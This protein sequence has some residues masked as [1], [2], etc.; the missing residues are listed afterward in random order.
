[1]KGGFYDDSTAELS[2]LLATWHH[3]LVSIFRSLEEFMI[4]V[5]VKIEFQCA[6]CK[7]AG[8]VEAETCFL[9]CSDCDAT[10]LVEKYV[11]LEEF[12]KLLDGNKD[13]LVLMP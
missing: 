10:G 11:S 3:R 8:E 5:R 1:M 2:H 13:F 6:E 4:N 12:K 9:N 7:G